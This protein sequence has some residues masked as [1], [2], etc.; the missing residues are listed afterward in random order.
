MLLEILN[1]TWS[2]KKYL[3]GAFKNILNK[4][5]YVIKDFIYNF[6]RKRIFFK[7]FQNKTWLEK[8]FVFGDFKLYWLEK[9][10]DFRDFK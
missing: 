9:Y 6:I 1:I 3:I 2:D 4:K 5:E 7:I 10:D 8:V